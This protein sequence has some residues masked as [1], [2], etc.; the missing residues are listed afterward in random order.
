MEEEDPAAIDGVERIE[1]EEEQF[2]ILAPVITWNDTNT[3]PSWET[4]YAYHEEKHEF[5]LSL[6]RIF[7]KKHH[8]ISMWLI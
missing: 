6:L 1:E 8:F 3:R 5:T 4:C 7:F 2:T